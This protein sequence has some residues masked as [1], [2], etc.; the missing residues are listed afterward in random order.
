V[1]PDN[2]T[3]KATH[4]I[5]AA[6]RSVDLKRSEST[7]KKSGI[8]AL[9]G[10]VLVFAA[11]V[12][13]AVPDGQ[14]KD[15]W[16][17]AIPGLLTGIGTLVLAG[18][19]VWLSLRQRV[20]DR[21]L[22]E[23]QRIAAEQ[24]GYREALRDAR[25]VFGSAGGASGPVDVTV[26]MYINVQ[27]VSPD[28]IFRVAISCKTTSPITRGELIWSHGVHQESIPFLT[29][30]SEHAFGGHWYDRSGGIRGTQLTYWSYATLPIEV[31][32]TDGRGYTWQRHG[33]D[34]P[35][36]TDGLTEV[37]LHQAS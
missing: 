10:T 27:N 5:D 9:A 26:M 11:L 14:L 17:I 8:T 13:L 29:P 33:Y 37:I 4:S 20:Q 12:F 15:F 30:N 18:T 23:E 25:K 6:A 35:Q 2:Q 7:L 16:R 3:A 22:R 28:P 21:Q 32:W 36:L 34:E 31:S 1:K 24:Q 19:T